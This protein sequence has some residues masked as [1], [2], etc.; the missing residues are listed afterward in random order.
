M[1]RKILHPALL[2]MIYFLFCL[3]IPVL[4]QEKNKESEENGENKILHHRVSLTLGHT[5][6]PSGSQNG[7]KNVLALPSWGLDYNY[8]LN[9]KWAIGIHSDFITETFTVIDFEGNKEFDRNRPL[10]LTLVGIFKPHD[11]WSFIA[12]GGYELSEEENLS[13]LR[14]GIERGWELGQEWEF[15]AT[16]QYDLKFKVYDSWMLGLGVSKGF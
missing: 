11:K 2:F 9:K 10:T 3:A 4:S 6:I 8:Q 13:L 7:E 1:K 12:G 16:L 14:L 15:F 5:H